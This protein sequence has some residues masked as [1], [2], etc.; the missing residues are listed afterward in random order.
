MSPVID[1]A[2]PGL[3]GAAGEPTR[4]DGGSEE[5]KESEP[6][7]LIFFT[8]FLQRYILSKTELFTEFSLSGAGRI[9]LHHHPIPPLT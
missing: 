8:I 4:W 3:A 9:L 6:G 1:K 5:G 2:C 7:D